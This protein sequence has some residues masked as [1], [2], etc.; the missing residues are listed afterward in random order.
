MEN[1]GR[2]KVT[3][4]EDMDDDDIM[5]DYEEDSYDDEYLDDE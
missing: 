5:G 3:T 2:S 4:V 1:L